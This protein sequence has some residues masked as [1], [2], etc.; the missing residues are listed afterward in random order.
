[1]KRLLSVLLLFSL[2]ALPALAD[3]LPLLE[4]YTA[5][6]SQP[7]DDGD[8]S[9]GTFVYSCRYPHADDTAP[10]GP[11]IN[12]FYEYLL[13]DTLDNYIPLLQDAYEGYDSSMI[14]TYTVTCNNDEYFSVLVSTERDNP[15][16]CL[17]T[18]EGHVF[19]R[20]KGSPGQTYT[21]PK[22][23][24]ILSANE[25]DEWLQNRQT[26]KANSIIRGM[27]WDMIRDNPE[28]LDYGD[29][30]EESL[31]YIFFPEENFFLDENGDPVFYLQ[32]GDLFAEVPEGTG[33]F[34]FPIAL[35]DILDEL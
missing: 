5:E 26:E 23:L 7:Y 8:L 19:S 15:D 31:S 11:E 13:N 3:P 16:L 9:A 10:G 18:W 22:V 35:E 29:V 4:D 28:G 30:T 32:P 14:V 21:L 2:L 12:A 27:V 20:T 25:N 17:T 1:M 6:I 24:G 33:L 34:T